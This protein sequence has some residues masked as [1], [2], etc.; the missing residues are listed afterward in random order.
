MNEEHDKQLG[1]KSDDLEMHT[2]LFDCYHSWESPM[3]REI[4]RKRRRELITRRI[5]LLTSK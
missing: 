3:F 4:S 5:E 1:F 2:M